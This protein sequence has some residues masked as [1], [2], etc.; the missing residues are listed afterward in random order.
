VDDGRKQLWVGDDPLVSR[1]VA[2]LKAASAETLPEAGRTQCC[3]IIATSVH[4]IAE[5]VK[6]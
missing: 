6:P 5:A 2:H 4:R 1:L 3:D